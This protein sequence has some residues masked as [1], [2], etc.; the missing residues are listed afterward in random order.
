MLKRGL[1]QGRG[2]LN[3]CGIRLENSVEKEGIWGVNL[4]T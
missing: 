2:W 4:T 3:K 1:R